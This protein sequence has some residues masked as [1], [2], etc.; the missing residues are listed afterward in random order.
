M[1]KAPFGT[2]LQ[3]TAPQRIH[4]DATAGPVAI[5][6]A[7]G[8]ALAGDVI[9][10]GPG[11]YVDWLSLKSNVT[12]SAYISMSRIC[13]ALAPVVQSPLNT[14]LAFGL[15][16]QRNLQIDVLR[17]IA[18]L[19]VLVTHTVLFRPPTG[20]LKWVIYGCGIGVELF[21]VLSG[22]LIS[23]LLFSEYQRSGHINFG[24]FAARRA[25]KI[26]PPLYLLIT[27]ALASRLIHSRMENPWAALTPFIHDVLFVQSYLPGTYG[28]FWSLAVE[29]HFYILLPLSLYFGIR[30]ARAGTNP[31]RWIPVGFFALAATC[32]TAR[33][34]T[35]LFVHPW[36]HQTHNFPTHLCLDALMFGVLLSYLAHFRAQQLYEFIDR[37]Y[38]KVAAGSLMLISPAFIAD[39][40]NPLF[41]IAGFPCLYLG[42]GGILLV[43]L[44]TKMPTQQSGLAALSTIGFIG[45]HSYSIYLWHVPLLIKLRDAEHLQAGYGLALYFVVT[46]V[47]GIGLSILIDIPVLGL[48]DRLWPRPG[49]AIATSRLASQKVA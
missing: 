13:R 31:F 16:Q 49:S 22:F 18:V 10:L 35:S 29:E 26:Y 3:R 40:K 5:S 21:F 45:K 11:E 43:M 47:V 44:R 12:L 15:T 25:M 30:R 33:I 42:F 36:A 38:W 6:A 8:S 1:A 23:G 48:R 28:H 39:T 32:V 17:G 4:V 7:L 34:A 14:K 2:A 9:E 24:R 46:L 41:M 37:N 20:R 27:L 19:M